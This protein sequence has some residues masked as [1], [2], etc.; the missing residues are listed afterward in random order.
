MAAGNRAI[1]TAGNFMLTTAGV[2]EDVVLGFL[3]SALLGGKLE[4]ALGGI[5][6]DGAL[7]KIYGEKT[8]IAALRQRV[9]EAEDTL[10]GTV[11]RLN[12]A[13][14][15][16]E[17]AREELAAARQTISGLQTAIDLNSVEALQERF[18]Q[19]LEETTAIVNSVRI[20]AEELSTLPNSQKLA[21]TA[22]LMADLETELSEI[23]TVV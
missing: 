12:V 13:D 21:E 1:L 22:S 8:G 20:V 18:D 4:V 19:I 5:V 23:Y 16:L 15:T 7:T 11:K 2:M 10:A 6:A 14:N 17:N 9:A 3:T